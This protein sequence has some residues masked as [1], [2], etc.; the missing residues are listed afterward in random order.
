MEVIERHSTL[1]L[2][3]PFLDLGNIAADRS[4]EEHSAQVSALRDR[5]AQVQRRRPHKQLDPYAE[6]LS[7]MPPL[8]GG[9]VAQA[10]T[11]DQAVAR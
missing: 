11:N 7:R 4:V 6:K 1:A 9:Q 3:G 8:G 2:G 5:G 10:E